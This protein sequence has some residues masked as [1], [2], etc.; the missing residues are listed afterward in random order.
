LAPTR[1]PSTKPI[2]PWI[3]A[4]RDAASDGRDPGPALQAFFKE[5]PARAQAALLELKGFR[6]NLF[7]LKYCAELTALP[8]GFNPEWCDLRGCT[9]LT[10]LPEG[11]NPEECSLFDC[12]GLTSLPEG[13][14]P[15]VCNLSGCAGL[16]D[17]PGSMTGTVCHEAFPGGSPAGEVR[18]WLR[19]NDRIMNEAMAERRA[20]SSQKPPGTV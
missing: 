20:A 10:A 5:D 9:G 14:N 2:D 1:H 4:L 11:F 13:F 17:L 12:T 8:E 6:P 3:P 19:F 18:A 16:V 15:D 7:T